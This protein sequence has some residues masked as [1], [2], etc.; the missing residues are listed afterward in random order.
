MDE[1]SVSLY[2]GLAKG[3]IL[4]SRRS[5]G[6][7]DAPVQ[8]INKNM[9]RTNFTMMS[10]CCS[11]TALQHLMPHIIIGN[12]N[13]FKAPDFMALLDATPRNVYLIRQKSAWNNKHVMKR[14]L[15][16]LA[17]ILTP[18][19]SEYYFILGV[20]A[21]GPHIVP[22]TLQGFRNSVVNFVLIP[23]KLTFLLQP[24]DTHGFRR[25]KSCMRREYQRK[26]SE[27]EDGKLS[28]QLFLE[29]MYVAIKQIFSRIKWRKAFLENGWCDSQQ[30]VSKS[31]K[32]WCHIDAMPVMSND[33]PSIENIKL[34][35]PGGNHIYR[36]DLC[37]PRATPVLPLPSS[38]QQAAPVLAL[39]APATPEP[40]DDRPIAHCTRSWTR[41]R[42]PATFLSSA[43]SSDPAPPNT[44]FRA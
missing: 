30:H 33:M 44:P 39:P 21:A 13:T 25:W 16:L 24:L 17:F 22:E 11:E 6:R 35:F 12:E 18:Y 29:V 38:S 4:F 3:N 28:I 23:A 8:R 9:L 40:I 7:Q 32:D 1:T 10:F 34:L 26:R 20:D 31:I 14:L 19:A 43:G 37:M 15:D 41:R 5:H 36:C 2:H 27:T 42:L